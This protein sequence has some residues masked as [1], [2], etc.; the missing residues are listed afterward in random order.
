MT[1]AFEDYKK[2]FTDL[3]E[4]LSRDSLSNVVHKNTSSVHYVNA[5]GLKGKIN[6]FRDLLDEPNIERK[7]L[8]ELRA[9]IFTEFDR[10]INTL[11]KEQEKLNKDFKN[12]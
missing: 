5:K 8:T 7:K 6:D 10:V 2:D 3:T 4:D 12:D 1:K 11:K 9:D